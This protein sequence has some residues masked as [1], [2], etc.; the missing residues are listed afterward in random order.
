[1]ETVLH[2]MLAIAR[3]PVNIGW[4]LRTLGIVGMTAALA[5]PAIA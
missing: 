4:L 3:K 5:T 2:S 1:M